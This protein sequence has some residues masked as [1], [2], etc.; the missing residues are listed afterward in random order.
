MRTR[1]IPP[2]FGWL[3]PAL[4]IG[5]AL[6]A[7]ARAQVLV[8]DVQANDP[9]VAGD[10]TSNTTAR[11]PRTVQ[12]EPGL[13]LDPVNGALV[14]AAADMQSIPACGPGMIPN[15][16]CGAPFPQCECG[17]TPASPLWDVPLAGFYTSADGGATWANGGTFNFAIPDA[18]LAYG[19][20]PLPGGG[21]SYA[22]GARCYW[23]GMGGF[24]S[25]ATRKATATIFFV[26]LTSSDDDGLTW[27]PAIAVD[28]RFYP[29]E[30]QDFD[31]LVVD[32]A[33]G[34]RFFGS[35]YVSWRNV[36]N[37][38]VGAHQVACSRDGGASFSAP[39]QV[40][41]S[42]WLED[43]DATMAIGPDGSLFLAW[44]RFTPPAKT[45]PFV[46]TA[47]VAISHDGG[48]TWSQPI[49][50]GPFIA[51]GGHPIPGA[52]FR[53]LVKVDIAA[54]PRPG[55]TTL[56]AAWPLDTGA[57]ARVVVATSSDGGLTWGA[58]ETVSTAEEG[59][60][61]FPAIAVAP[62]GRVDV[63]Y[64]G[65][66]VRDPSWYGPGNALADAWL[67]SKAPGGSWSSPL[68]L[69]TVSSDATGA[70]AFFG[71]YNTL[72]S[73]AH[74]AYFAHTDTRNAVDC[75]AVDEFYRAE[76]GI[77]PGP[78]PLPAIVDVCAPEVL[79]TDIYVSRVDFP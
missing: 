49:A 2:R 69:T 16:I 13:A 1:S 3:V 61:F 36:D 34:S 53:H 70:G 57:G 46:S 77:V 19:P 68:R 32:T 22:Q 21:F 9:Q 47:V 8:Y 37:N 44:W 20:R 40:G 54:D 17:A 10:P 74:H 4:A 79:N 39:V 25:G 14:A 12:A 5:A 50:I 66:V 45:A 48:A 56:Y 71:D 26:Q 73:D 62:T 72:V 31:W 28:D 23:T 42:T 67:V 35:V 29:N 24:S 33:P 55:S 52:A 18:H 58:P 6:A 60:A 41:A 27:S 59:Y 63:G 11:Y 43:V 65:L 51:S 78:V 7:D 38:G 76:L 75:D 30:D 64:Q 15:F